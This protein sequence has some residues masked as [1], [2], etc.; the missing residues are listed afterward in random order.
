MLIEAIMLIN[1]NA[2]K[3]TGKYLTYLLKTKLH[4]LIIFELN[5]SKILIKMM[6][7][8]VFM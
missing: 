1:Q 8:K 2:I 5:F 7:G 6:S 3:T 4:V